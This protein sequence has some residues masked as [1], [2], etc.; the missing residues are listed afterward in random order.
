M[1]EADYKAAYLREKLMRKSAEQLLEDRSRELYL[2]MQTLETTLAELKDSQRQLIHSEKMASLGVVSA[3]VA[4]EINNPIGFIT[5]NLNSLTRELES[6]Q[7]FFNVI[8]AAMQASLGSVD[9]LELWKKE[10]KH[11]DINY[12]VEDV[13][14]ITTE[15]MSGL[16]RVTQIVNDLRTFTREDSEE[17]SAVD[18]NACLQS[19]L[20][21]L[22]NQIKYKAKLELDLAELPM[23]QGFPGKLNQVFTNLLSNAYQSIEQQGVIHVLT[24]IS[25][26]FIEVIIKD[27]GSGIS[28][29]NMKNL[30]TPFFTTKPP[31]EGTGLGLSI[32]YGIIEDHKGQIT[33]TSEE[34]RGSCFTV[35]LPIK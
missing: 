35:K 20:N 4:H 29:E 19:A 11:W 22:Q 2:S 32:S 16:E 21:I 31:G 9:L 17:M 28:D 6:F 24:R 13:L 8:D 25:T 14:A 23:I 5:S 12:I 3:G 15:S 1:A 27:N 34:G 18:I 10:V 26:T 7:S 33:V 30:F